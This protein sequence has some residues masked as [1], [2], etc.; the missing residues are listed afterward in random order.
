MGG[1]GG[2]GASVPKEIEDAAREIIGIGEEQ[3]AI[4]LPLIQAGGNVAEEVLRTGTSPALRPAILSSLEATRRRGS[5]EIQGLEEAL[6]RRGVTGTQFQEAVAPA[7]AALATQTAQIPSSF[8]IPI[9]EQA[10]SGALGQT[11]NALASLQAGATG[12]AAGAVPGRQSGGITG[13]LGGGLSGAATGAL[14]PGLGPAGAI[15]GGL[16]GAGKGAK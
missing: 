10:T 2:G 4:G 3:L 6:T 11:G 5:E 16:L 8:G 7:R 1:K 13:A 12:G 14:I 15:V 9:F